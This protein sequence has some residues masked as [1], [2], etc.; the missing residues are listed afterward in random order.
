MR[1]SAGARALAAPPARAHASEIDAHTQTRFEDPDSDLV[2]GIRRHSRF[3]GEK[4]TLGQA[5]DG[6]S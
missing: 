5:A 4:Q 1:R 3:P 6:V 2:D